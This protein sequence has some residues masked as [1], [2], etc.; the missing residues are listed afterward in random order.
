MEYSKFEC[1]KC[2]FKCG[3]ISHWNDHIISKK[4]TGEKRKE[5]CDKILS[6][7]CDLCDYIPTKTT[8]LKLHYLNK[9]GTKEERQ[10]DF[11]FYCNKC[12]FGCLVEVL[13]TRH[14]ETKKH[15]NIHI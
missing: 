10:K 1:E 12:D 4:H 3:F 9:H 13:F 8:N 11:T 5:R 15:I 7:K 2:Q 14:L 6:K